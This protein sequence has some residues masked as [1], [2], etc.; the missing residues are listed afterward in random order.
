MECVRDAKSRTQ[1]YLYKVKDYSERLDVDDFIFQV[2]H[3]AMLRRIGFAIKERDADYALDRSYGH[4]RTPSAE[5]LGA[6]DASAI[7]GHLSERSVRQ[8]AEH[9]RDLLANLPESLR[10]M[11]GAEG[12]K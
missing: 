2:A 8:P 3:P 1:V 5:D 4:P 7:F 10:A 6:D 9:L 11:L 12:G